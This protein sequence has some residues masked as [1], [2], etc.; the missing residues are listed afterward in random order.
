MNTI[1]ILL[2]DDHRIV[3][4]GVRALLEEQPDFSVVG[5]A[6]DG[7]EA[8]ELA[9]RLQPD[10]LLLD[11]VMPALNGL[12]VLRLLRHR[13]SRT[14]ALVLSMYADE[15]RVIHALRDGAAGYVL[16]S[17]EPETLA[18][19]V[20]IVAAGGR[21][22]CPLLADRIVAH[23]VHQPDERVADPY[24]A[25]T[26]R[27]RQVLQLAAE[28]YTNAE[29]A[30]RLSISRRTVESHRAKVMHK[31]GLHSHTDLVRYALRRGI[32]PPDL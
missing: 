30:G 27:E 24:D 20:R 15:A 21:Y 7:I 1:T 2:A 11:L 19:A 32:L 8:I 12:E 3:R 22:V 6:S 23:Y 17:A 9:E 28:G 16:K 18:Q 26:A 4:M 13:V 25:L 29:I 31:L 5:E 10:V 14:R